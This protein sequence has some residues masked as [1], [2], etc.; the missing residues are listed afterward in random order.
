VVNSKPQEHGRMRMKQC[1]ECG[2]R[3][4]IAARVCPECGKRYPTGGLKAVAWIG[5]IAIGVIFVGF[6]AHMISDDEMGAKERLPTGPVAPPEDDSEVL[7]RTTHSEAKYCAKSILSKRFK[8]PT[9]VEFSERTLI[10]Q[11]KNFALVSVVVDA[12]N[13]FGVKLRS[14]WCYIVRFEPPRGEKFVWDTNWGVWE[15]SRPADRTDVLGRKAAVGWPGAQE[16]L[17]AEARTKRTKR[18]P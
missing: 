16:A 8:A 12:P 7:S 4:S 11:E 10:E 15:C 18:A 3:A 9:Q 2:T 13:S 14:T 6:C 17:E 1:K 5:V